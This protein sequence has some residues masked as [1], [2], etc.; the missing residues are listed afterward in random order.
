MVGIEV[1]YI[2]L[3]AFTGG[4]LAAG[5]GWLDSGKAFDPRKFGSSAIRAFI[6]GI[7]FAIAYVFKD[8][9]TVIDILIAFIGGA[10]VDVIGNR[11]AG[12]IK[13]KLSPKPPGT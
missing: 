1:I 5:L 11:A 2:A 6:A 3:A 10:G 7:V 8:G 13:T 9:I 12:A 4:I